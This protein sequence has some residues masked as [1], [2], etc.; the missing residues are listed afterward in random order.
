MYIHFHG[1]FSLIFHTGRMKYQYTHWYF[2]QINHPYYLLF[3]YCPASLSF[4]SFQC[5]CPYTDAMYF[6]NIHYHFLSLS[7]FLLVPQTD[8]LLQSCSL[9]IWIY[10]HICIYVYISLLDLAST[11]KGNIQPLSFWAWLT[12]LNMMICSSIHLP[13]NNII[14]FF[15]IA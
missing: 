13:K 12:S 6:D 8:T 2:N 5:V 11:Y 15:F 14:P 1:S 9:C 4:N 10:D 7:C 3:L